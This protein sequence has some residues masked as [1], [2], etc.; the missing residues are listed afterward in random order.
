[1]SA[2]SSLSGVGKKT[3]TNGFAQF[4]FEFKKKNSIDDMNE[5]QM[6][7]GRI[8]Q[9]ILRLEFRVCTTEYQFRDYFNLLFYLLPTT[10]G[11]E[12]R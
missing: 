3:K 7:A 1:M 4:M 9:V 8:W 10:T 11:Y 2:A 12:R 5:A 6:Q